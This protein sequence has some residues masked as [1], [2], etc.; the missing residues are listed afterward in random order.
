MRTLI[1]TTYLMLLATGYGCIGKTPVRTARPTLNVTPWE[2]RTVRSAAS[3]HTYRYLFAAGP[4]EDAP[5]ML[6]LHGGI[7]DHH[8]WLNVAGLSKRFNVYALE[9]PDKSLFYTGHIEDYGEISADFLFAL[10]ITRVFVAGVSMGAL[11]AI[12][13]VSRK[14][15]LDVPAL[16][17]FSAVMLG[18]TEEEVEERTAIGRRAL[19]FAPDRLR[20]IIE[21][22]VK[23][24]EFDRAPGEIQMGDIYYTRPYPY[25]FQVFSMVVNQ[26]GQRQDTMAIECPVLLLH[27][28]DDETM[29]V[30]VA[31]LSVPVFN[32][33]KM[34]EFD[35]FGHAMVFSHGPEFV[36]AIYRFL[37]QRALLR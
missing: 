30:H 5:A 14:K 3:G 29:P 2:A 13:L 33:A 34:V 17:V 15:E 37:R 18:I 9:W 36:Q 10:G 35:G 16:F 27:G 19:G 20:S 21:W 8:M 23:R 4:S 7:F 24:T 11:A 28:T 31:R 26:G 6:L 1:I 25:Y 32:D 22:R 12:D